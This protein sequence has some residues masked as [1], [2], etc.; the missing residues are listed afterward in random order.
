MQIGDRGTGGLALPLT[1]SIPMMVKG[2]THFQH[3]SVMGLTKR[4]TQL[5]FSGIENAPISNKL[6]NILVRFFIN[7]INSIL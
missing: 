6:V 5:A 1:T 3:I 4:P 2:N 7:V